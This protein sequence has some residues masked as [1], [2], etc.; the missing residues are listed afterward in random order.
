MQE[1][2]AVFRTGEILQEGRSKLQ[3]V[4][5]A[6]ADLQIQD[7]SLVWNS[8]LMEALEFKNL[9]LQALVTLEGAYERKESRGAHAREDFSERDDEAWMKHTLAWVDFESGKVRLRY[10]PVHAHT[11][12]K[13]AQYIPPKKRVY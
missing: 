2:C 5:A 13:D 10:R 3:E 11:L 7:R 9:F 12:S 8:D 1:H 4:F 6:C